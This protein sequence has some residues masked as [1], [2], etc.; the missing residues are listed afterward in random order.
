MKEVKIVSVGMPNPANNNCGKHRIGFG[1][2]NMGFIE[3]WFGGV[4]DI[5]TAEE[6]LEIAEK[7]VNALNEWK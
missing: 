5:K 7:I 3:I 4:Q 2:D 6:A 1:N